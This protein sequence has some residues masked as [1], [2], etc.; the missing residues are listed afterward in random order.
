[1][2]PGGKLVNLLSKTRKLFVAY[3]PTVSPVNIQPLIL[4][5]DPSRRAIIPREREARIQRLTY[6]N[7]DQEP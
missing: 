6:I 7:G 1:M 4:Q 3:L 5:A 2:I